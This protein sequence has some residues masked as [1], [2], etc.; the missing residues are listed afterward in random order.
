MILHAVESLETVRRAAALTDREVG[1]CSGTFDLIHCGHLAFLSECRLRCDVLVVMVG[2]DHQ[3]KQRKGENR[4]TVPEQQRLKMVAALKCVNH[5]FLDFWGKHDVTG[6]EDAMR[7]LRPKRYFC[8]EDSGEIR[9]RSDIA[10]RCGVSMLVIP[11]QS[12]TNPID[13]STTQIIEKLRSAT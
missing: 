8:S 11:R 9:Q 3:V 4:P 7:L 10:E 5:C 2:R 12:A 13:V 1:F 6:L